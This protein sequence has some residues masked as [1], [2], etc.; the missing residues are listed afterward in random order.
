MRFRWGWWGSVAQ[1]VQASA[2]FLSTL[3]LDKHKSSHAWRLAGAI[4]SGVCLQPAIFFFFYNPRICVFRSCLVRLIQLA[5]RRTMG[6]STGLQLFSRGERLAGW[7]C[8]SASTGSRET[9]LLAHVI[10]SSHLLSSVRERG[11]RSVIFHCAAYRDVV[12]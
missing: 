11:K 12:P 4:N 8:E 7:W 1:T 2:K 6:A 3:S 10:L 5:V 9:L